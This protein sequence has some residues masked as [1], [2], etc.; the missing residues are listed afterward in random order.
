MENDCVMCVC[1]VLYEERQQQWR[2][3]NEWECDNKKSC[4]MTINYLSCRLCIAKEKTFITYLPV[5]DTVMHCL[6]TW[7]VWHCCFA[8][9]AAAYSRCYCNCY[10]YCCHYFY[11]VCFV[12]VF[13]FAPFFSPPQHFSHCLHKYVI[14]LSDFRAMP[15]FFHASALFCA[16]F[17]VVFIYLYH[18]HIH[19]YICFVR[20]FP[21]KKFQSVFFA[22]LAHNI[23]CCRF[24]SLFAFTPNIIIW[25][26]RWVGA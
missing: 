19:L 5:S 17:F 3:K 20:F 16:R 23:F 10:C 15:H 2:K 13:S 6:I 7:I 22:S 12:C 24:F 21:Q 14:S 25:L 26:Y 9:T 4:T 8:R 1:S 18:T 11:T